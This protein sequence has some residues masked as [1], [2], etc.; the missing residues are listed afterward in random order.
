MMN[1]ENKT[2]IRTG[3]TLLREKENF[4]FWTFQ[5]CDKVFIIKDFSYWNVGQLGYLPHEKYKYQLL[6]NQQ[7]N[8]CPKILKM[9]IHLLF[10]KRKIIEKLK[11]ENHRKNEI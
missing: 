1:N 5:K 4:G 8:Y 7:F 11:E 6:Q 9:Y 10:L 3:S 2:T